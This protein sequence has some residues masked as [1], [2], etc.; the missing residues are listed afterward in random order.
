VP[1]FEKVRHRIALIRTVSM[2][3]NT[4]YPSTELFATEPV[5]GYSLS[6]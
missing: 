2:W 3:M 4:R 1:P 6:S 5:H